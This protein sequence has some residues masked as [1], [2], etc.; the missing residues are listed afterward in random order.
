MHITKFAVNDTACKLVTYSQGL[1]LL[2]IDGCEPINAKAHWTPMQI[3]LA[4]GARKLQTA[5]MQS[6]AITYPQCEICG[7][8][9]PNIGT[10]VECDDRAF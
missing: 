9:C 4:V 6:A 3:R 2:L 7:A 10:C 5:L 8:T 1:T